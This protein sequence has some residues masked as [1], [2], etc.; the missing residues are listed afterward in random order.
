MKILIW[1]NFK[2]LERKGGPPTYL[3]NL[4]QAVLKEGYEGIDFIDLYETEG[5]KSQLSFYNRVRKKIVQKLMNAKGYNYLRFK[6]F[7]YGLEKANPELP[8]IDFN[9]YDFIHFHSTADYFQFRKIRTHFRGKTVLTIHSPKPPHFEFIEDVF[10]IGDGRITPREFDRL[11]YIDDF[12]VTDCDLLLFPCR[13]AMEPF[14]NAWA[15]F[16]EKIMHKKV[17]FT[18]TGIPPASFSMSKEVIRNK[19]GIDKD[20][21]VFSYIGRHNEIK[22]YDLLKSAA[23]DLLQRYPNVVFLIA[24][25]E[26]PIKG[27]EHDRWVEVGWTTDPHAITNASDC[28]VLPNRETFFDLVLLEV[29]SL[30]KKCILSYTG[31]NKFFEQFKSKDLFFFYD[32]CKDNLITA[33]EQFIDTEE[34]LMPTKVKELYNNK[35]TGEKFLQNYLSAMR[36]AL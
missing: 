27:L 12:A 33:L 25:A 1:N 20:S 21:I 4:K 2:L 34:Y 31:G 16:A 6:L 18:P 5:E 26:H 17:I 14:I 7:L 23:E 9:Q 3:Y 30:N 13:E 10:K 28:F 22:G 29:L 19:W 36:G 15:T 24:G 35:F 8:Q 32:L 11:K